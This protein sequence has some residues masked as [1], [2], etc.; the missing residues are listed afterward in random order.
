MLGLERRLDSR[1]LLFPEDDIAIK[2][3][4]EPTD[5]RRGGDMYGNDAWMPDEDDVEGSEG[6]VKVSAL[7]CSGR[8]GSTV[9]DAIRRMERGHGLPEARPALE[10]DISSYVTTGVDKG[11]A[12]EAAEDGVELEADDGL[13]CIEYR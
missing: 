7:F 4:A 9:A 2:D 5:G 13:C 1:L 8:P 6:R 11:E 12:A 3:D 10:P